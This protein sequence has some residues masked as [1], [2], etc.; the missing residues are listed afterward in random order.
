M[1]D[2]IKGQEPASLW[3]YRATPNANYDDLPAPVKRELK[4]SLLS[5]QRNLCAYCMEQINYDNM[6]VEHF[7]ARSVDESLELVYTNL[8]A[9]CKGREGD[10]EDRQTCDTQKK[11]RQ[12]TF[13]FLGQQI[14]NAVKYR[15]A[16]GE[17]LFPGHEDEVNTVLN[18]NDQLGYLMGNRKEAL[19]AFQRFLKKKYLGK[20]L[21]KDE[22]NK[23]AKQILSKTN[24]DAYCGI[25]IWYL[26]R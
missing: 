25:I 8:F 1:L 5:E 4:L 15:S 12:L 14:T 24:R 17:L 22:K 2:I 20:T 3:R 9:V 21:S 10:P 23:I 18:L 7:V 19:A 6:K 13:S 16:T 26:L 11:N